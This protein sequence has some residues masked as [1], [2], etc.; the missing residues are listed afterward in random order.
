MKENIL[1]K[2]LLTLKCFNDR[3]VEVL[4]LDKNEINMEDLLIC[5]DS[6]SFLIKDYKII[7]NIFDDFIEHNIFKKEDIKLFLS[8]FAANDI[9]MT[10]HDLS[11]ISK[12][13]SSVTN[14]LEHLINNGQTNE[15]HVVLLD[16]KNINYLKFLF[17][18]IYINPNESWDNMLL[19]FQ[20]VS[21]KHLHAENLILKE[22]EKDLNDIKSDEYNKKLKEAKS[23]LENYKDKQ[24]NS[25]VKTPKNIT[26]KNNSNSKEKE[27]SIEEINDNYEILNVVETKEE[28]KDIIGL[29]TV[30]KMLT[31]L[32][33]LYSEDIENLK[34]HKI[35]RDKGFILYGEPG[36][37]KTMLCK[38]FAKEL[39]ALF[40]YLSMEQF[41]SRKSESM[42][43][44]TLFQE[45]DLISKDFPEKTI[46]VF[47]D[48]L[49]SLR[50]RGQS[51]HNNSYYDGFTNEMLYR[52]DNLPKN[53]MIIGATN[54]LDKLD[55]AIIRKGRLGNQYEVKNDFKKEEI[56]TFIKNYFSEAKMSTLNKYATFIATMIYYM[57]GSEISNILN[58]I[59]QNYYFRSGKEKIRTLILD[60]IYGEKY[61]LSD[62]E[63][64]EDEEKY[65]AYHEAGHA[66][67]Y[68]NF[69][70]IKT[71]REVSIYPTEKALGFISFNFEQANIT[72]DDLKQRVIINLAG[73]Y[74]EKLITNNLSTG[75]SSDL[76]SANKMINRYLKTYGMGGIE[77]YSSNEEQI[78]DYMKTKLDKEHE[79]LLKEFSKETEKFIEN[80]KDVIEILAKDLVKDKVLIDVFD[81]Y[82]KLL[83]KD[84]NE[85]E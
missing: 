85:K 24:K 3:N 12:L 36:T 71:L 55:K 41:V 5:R 75:A 10:I 40:V 37:G 69:Y 30:K 38:A 58:K 79:N 73:R 64:S 52:I 60:T 13:D 20:E 82:E 67:A 2:I 68:I 66:L 1:L 33:K 21:L 25:F 15:I 76:S 80:N 49:D 7:N 19:D 35:E 28:F 53:V 4:L 50:G 26:S 6:N 23:I 62:Y 77:N 45:I 42:T 81:K 14:T 18:C 63:M 34:K 78:S 9:E 31:K 65:V 44:P 48:E 84:I 16:K 61:N 46:V 29:N 54:N 59:K 70:G 8:L 27:Y 11:K 32:I 83:K 39:N 74:A 72:K 57:N 47:L 51:S 56:I 22:F 17:R 43:I